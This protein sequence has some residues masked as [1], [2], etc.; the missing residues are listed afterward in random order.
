[1]AVARRESVKKL[2]KTTVQAISL[3][4]KALLEEDMVERVCR[5]A[6]G[7]FSVYFESSLAGE[8]DTKHVMTLEQHLGL[9]DIIVK[10]LLY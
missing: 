6:R 8:V 2:T 9:A 4:G 1:M 10:I 3:A 7:T 5:E